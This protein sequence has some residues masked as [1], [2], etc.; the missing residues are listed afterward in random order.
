MHQATQK[1]FINL[2]QTDLYIYNMENND[3]CPYG[4]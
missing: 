3:V 1:G 4:L 2:M